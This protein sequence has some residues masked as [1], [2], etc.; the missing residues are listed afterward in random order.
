MS[1]FTLA[2]LHYEP[3]EDL[4]GMLAPFDEAT[5]DPDFLTFRE[6][7]SGPLDEKTGKHGYYSNKNAKYDWFVPGG[8][9]RGLLKLKPGATTGRYASISDD[10]ACP[11]DLTHCDSAQ[12]KDIDFALSEEA[13]N[14]ALRVWDYLVE[15]KPWVGKPDEEPL[16]LYKPKYYRDL[17]GNRETYAKEASAFSTYAFLTPDGVWHEPGQMG[18]FGFSSQTRK[19]KAEYLEAFEREIVHANPERYLTILDCH[20]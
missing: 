19:S 11:D 9:W 18:W 7:E 6:D 12:I 5:T 16:R 10:P 3:Y 13:Y 1:H 8:R 4:D 2:V 17:Y 15:G 14:R 20:I